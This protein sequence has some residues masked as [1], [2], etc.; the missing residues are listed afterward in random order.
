MNVTRAVQSQKAS[1]GTQLGNSQGDEYLRRFCVETCGLIHHR[2]QSD[3][4]SLFCE[5]LHVLGS[6]DTTIL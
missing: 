5:H 3:T 2:V 4:T 6:G 1:W